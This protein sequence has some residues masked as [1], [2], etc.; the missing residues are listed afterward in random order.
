MHEIWEITWSLER[1]GMPRTTITEP[2][3][4]RKAKAILAAYRER[5]KGT[6]KK[7][8]LQPITKWIIDYGFEKYEVTY[9]PDGYKLLKLVAIDKRDHIPEVGF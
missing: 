4:M 5:Q 2:I 1:E 6:G 8:K 3:S 7:A 9:K